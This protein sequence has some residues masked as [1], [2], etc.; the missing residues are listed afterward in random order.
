MEKAKSFSFITSWSDVVGEANAR[1]SYPEK[2]A[3]GIL[4][5]KVIDTAYA[6]ELSMQKEQYLEKLVE[7]GYSGAVSDI[8]FISGSPKKFRK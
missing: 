5:V 6:Q 4:T 3:G 2:L 1:I 7:L 8:K